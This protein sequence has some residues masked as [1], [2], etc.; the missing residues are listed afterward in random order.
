[1]VTVVKDVRDHGHLHSHPTSMTQIAFTSSRAICS[2][3]AVPD[4][5]YF[6][7]QPSVTFFPW[8]PP[9]LSSLLAVSAFHATKIPLDPTPGSLAQPSQ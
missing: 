8:V 3:V 9:F 6:S 7:P 2:E 4:L 5:C 1:M